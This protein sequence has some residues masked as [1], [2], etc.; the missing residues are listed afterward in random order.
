MISAQGLKLPLKSGLG[1]LHQ[2]QLP[3]DGWL[4]TFGKSR[5]FF[6]N[7]R[8]L[9]SA[10][11]AREQVLPL[12]QRLDLQ[13]ANGRKSEAWLQLH[14]PR[15]KAGKASGWL[16]AADGDGSRAPLPALRSLPG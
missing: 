11:T 5:R 1:L 8:S 12:R 6:P 9:T 14:P 2:L 10:A 16:S 4:A 13:F 15:L 3:R 7:A